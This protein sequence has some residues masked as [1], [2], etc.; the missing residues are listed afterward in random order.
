MKY[1]CA[2]Q[3]PETSHEEEISIDDNNTITY[4]QNEMLDT[5][6]FVGDSVEI[7]DMIYIGLNYTDDM[8]FMFKNKGEGQILSC[9]SETQVDLDTP[10]GILIDKVFKEYREMI[11]HIVKWYYSRGDVSRRF[12]KFPAPPNL[13]L[14]RLLNKIRGN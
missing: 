7:E 9:K 3:N 4:N 10:F 11:R 8:Y 6:V 14:L 1:T 5:Y 13:H 2:L 12:L